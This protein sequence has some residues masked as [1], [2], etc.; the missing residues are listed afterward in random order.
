MAAKKTWRCDVAHPSLRS[1]QGIRKHRV[2]II[3]ERQVNGGKPVRRE[4]GC[5]P[6]RSDPIC[7][8]E[9][10]GAAGM[11]KFEERSKREL[12]AGLRT[13]LKALEPSGNF[14]LVQQ[15]EVVNEQQAEECAGR[16]RI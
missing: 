10:K 7:L 15:G 12:L 9:S 11:D 6:A 4:D 14:T 2:H 1:G 13:I 16:L 3:P 8:A 5:P